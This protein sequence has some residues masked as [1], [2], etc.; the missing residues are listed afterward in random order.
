MDLK[1]QIKNT[2]AGDLESFNQIILEYQ[3]LVYNQA[4]RIMGERDAAEDATQ[5]AFISAYKKLHTFRGG[6]FK[7]WLLR[8]VSNACYDEYRRRKR[9]P[10]VPLFPEG[11]DGDDKETPSWLEDQG[12]KPEEF[13]L[14]RELS[15]VIQICLDRLDFEFR[16]IVVLVDIQGMDYK[17]AAAII[18]RPLGTI[19][20]RLARARRN[21]KDC[22]MSFK[23]LLP[24]E[25]RHM[26]EV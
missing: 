7:S 22:L 13:T 2:L 16:T 25:L 9:K 1:A 10:V 24:A 18:D 5:E 8:I 6:S 11:E 15:D 26:G 21:L 20:S 14:R 3:T 17:T 19:K 4:F 23:E 12:E